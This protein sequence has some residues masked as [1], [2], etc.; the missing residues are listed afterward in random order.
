MAG[1]LI[2]SVPESDFRESSSTNCIDAFAHI[3][4]EN[5]HVKVVLFLRHQN[6]TSHSA[7][8]GNLFPK[9]GIKGRHQ[10]ISQV[11]ISKIQQVIPPIFN[12]LGL[13]PCKFFALS[14]SIDLNQFLRLIQDS[15]NSLAED[16][17]VIHSG[18]DNILKNIALS[19][20]ENIRLGRPELL[21][22]IHALENM[23]LPLHINAIYPT[24]RVIIRDK[25]DGSHCR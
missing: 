25:R 6:T 21:I 9:E 23:L 4:G 17:R 13:M 24:H 11:F 3:N 22:L 12:G 7:P 19:I 1:I 2:K 20:L 18:R 16:T 14:L 10:S 5:L 15:Q 8:D